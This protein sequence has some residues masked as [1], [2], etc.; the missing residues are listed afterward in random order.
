MS[1]IDPSV[2]MIALARRKVERAGL[3]IDLQPGV[4]EQ[5]AF[6]NQSFDVV[7]STMMMHQLPDDVK[8]QGLAEVARVLKPGGRLLVLDFRRAEE[9]EKPRF[10][11]PGLWNSGIQDQPAHMQEAGFSQ[12]ETGKT[13]FFWGQLC[14][15][16]GRVGSAGA[17]QER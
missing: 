8:R 13:R 5:L 3:S 7:L 6:P 1:G 14:F 10:T 9:G 2:Q 11:H 4:I 12:M 15:A 17:A 16:L